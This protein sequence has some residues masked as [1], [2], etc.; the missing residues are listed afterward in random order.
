MNKKQKSTRNVR[1]I[2]P[3]PIVALVIFSLII[4]E[5]ISDLD[6]IWNYNTARAILEG[7][8]PYKDI[9]MI[10]TPLLP[11]VTAVFLK[12]FANELIISRILA[13]T[14]WAGILFTTYKILKLLI[15]E[16]NLSLILT[17]LI[18]IL[19]R[20]CYCID[21]NVLVLLIAL[22]VLYNEIKNMNKSNIKSDFWIGILAGLA[23]C[24]K[25]SI[26]ITLAV[27]VVIYKLLLIEDRKQF[28]SIIKMVGIRILGILIPI[29]ILF[30]YLILTGALQE[31]INY[32]ILGISIFSNRI[33]YG[34]LLNNKK[35][36]IKILS[37][38]VPAT[39]AINSMVIIIAKLLKK[40]N[41]NIQKLLITLIYSTSII[42]VM[43]PISDEIHFLIGSFITIIS[44]IYT[45][46]L[47]AK[48]IYNKI[49]WKRKLR[50]YKIVTL[51]IWLIIFS[52][53]STVAINNFDIY[54]KTEKNTK[55]SH[56]KYIEIKD[57]L[58]KR[59]NNLKQYIIE[60]EEQ[61]KKVYILDAEAAIYMLTSD[62][63]NKDYDM[64]L[65]GNIGKDGEEGQIQKIQQR[66]KNVVYLIRKESLKLN[67]QT[68]SNVIK[69]IRENLQ[70]IEEIEIYEVYR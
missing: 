49:P 1:Q 20:D 13:A 66:D 24:T 46:C 39:I 4:I 21:Y 27:V 70:K 22:I 38:V 67:W 69:Y 56:F 14:I 61:G 40:D 9:S 7:F 59:I 65:K 2:L 12:I 53:I 64:F 42:I 52:F 3:V 32:A 5:P 33:T 44:M 8:I 16:E 37:I 31:F 63:Y 11:M 68:P 25:Q 35:I 58:E 48:K 30:A 26:G 36:E 50:A 28:K 57:Y 41:E 6:E 43:Y 34:K 54:I 51:I 47:L 62:R 29:V 18:G 15:K 10:T 55:I 19:L 45:I 23:I 60:N 17:S